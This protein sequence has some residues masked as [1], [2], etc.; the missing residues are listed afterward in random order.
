MRLFRR[1]E[2]RLDARL[3]R[4][5]V[6]GIPVRGTN[7]TGTTSGG[8]SSTRSLGALTHRSSRSSTASIGET[9]LGDHRLALLKPETYMNESGPLDLGGARGSSRLRATTC[10]SFTT[11][12]T[13]SS[14]DCRHGPAVDWAAQ[15]PALDRAGSRDTGVPAAADRRRS[16][17]TRRSSRRRGLRPRPVRGARGSGR[18]RRSGGRRGRNPRFSTV[19][20]TRSVDST[21]LAAEA[22][23]AQRGSWF[24]RV[25]G[26]SAED[27][28]I[29]ERH[30]VHL[31]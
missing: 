21:E 30:R 3:V 23:R 24:G 27:V 25:R 11:T 17:G 18:P 14:D 22:S 10:W 7:A 1:G 28:R 6:S 29:G 8:W 20:R 12:S 15:R 13:S 26:G 31:F 9:R 2:T 4:S 19:S 5:R 16:A